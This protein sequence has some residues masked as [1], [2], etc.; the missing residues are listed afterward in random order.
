MIE[1]VEELRVESQV[2]SF[3]ELGFL[4]GIEIETRLEISSEN[5]ATGRPIASFEGVSCGYS[6]LPCRNQRNTERRCVHQGGA[7]ARGLIARRALWNVL[8]AACR[9]PR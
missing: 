3:G 2:E 8:S 6:H 1:D 5:V 9:L 4:E 7:L